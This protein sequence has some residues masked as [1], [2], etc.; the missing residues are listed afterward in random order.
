MNKALQNGGDTYVRRVYWDAVIRNMPR[1]DCNCL[2][3]GCGIRFPFEKYI[4]M[5]RKDIIDCIDIFQFTKEEIPV[6]INRY[7]NCSAEEPLDVCEEEYDCI[8]CFEV[9]EHVDRTDELIRNCYNHLKNGGGKLF[10]AVP[11]LASIF[12]RVELL[13]GYQPHLLES[14]NEFPNCGMGVF[15]KK[16]NPKNK[17]IHHIRGITYYAMKELL[18]VHGF[19]IIKCNGYINKYK[20]PVQ[21]ASVIL[22]ICSKKSCLKVESSQISK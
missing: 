22:Y 12:S 10:I 14:S 19:E 18:R 15:G 17:S 2:D 7:F 8:F 3:I 4:F 1:Y 5:R 20:V 13:L 21:F 16:N 6:C 11:N 9:L